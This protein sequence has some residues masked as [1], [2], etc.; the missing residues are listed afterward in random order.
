MPAYY[1]V[2]QEVIPGVDAVGLEG[3]ALSKHSL[4]LDF[5][6]K[7]AGVIPILTFFSATPA[8]LAGLMEDQVQKGVP[9]PEEHWF[10][11]A[12]GLKTISSLLNSLEDTPHPESLRLTKELTEFQ[13]VLQA[14]RSRNVCWH[15][16]IDI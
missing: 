12:D 7:Q 13:H 3:R 5:L 1:I 4:D 15:L 9:R 16:G 10:S 6:A 2:L 8:E 11:A 14:A